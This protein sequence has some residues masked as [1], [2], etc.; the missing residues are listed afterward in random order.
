[1]ALRSS[2][3][4]FAFASAARRVAANAERNA[5]RRKEHE[6]RK[7]T[8]P[9]QIKRHAGRFGL[10]QHFLVIHPVP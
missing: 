2:A 10:P 3:P 5:N 4:R 1:V 6:P 8:Q 7:G 9:N